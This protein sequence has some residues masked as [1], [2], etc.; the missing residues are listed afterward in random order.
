[1]SLCDAANKVIYQSKMSRAMARLK[2]SAIYTCILDDK[3]ISPDR[4]R[5]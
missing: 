5:A 4:V 1:M 3:G 2:T